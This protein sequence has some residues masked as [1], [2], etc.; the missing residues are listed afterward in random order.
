MKLIATITICI[1]M[2]LVGG[3][4]NKKKFIEAE[5]EA[6]VEKAEKTRNP[7][8]ILSYLAKTS[9]MPEI[10]KANAYCQ[11]GIL[12]AKNEN[13]NEAIKYY[14]K[15]LDTVDNKVFHMS[16]LIRGTVLSELARLYMKNKDYK[17]A[18]QAYIDLL[19]NHQQYPKLKLNRMGIYQEIA[20]ISMDMKDYQYQREILRKIL[21]IQK[22]NSKYKPAYIATTIALIAHSYNNSKDYQNGVKW[23]K[24]AIRYLNRGKA[25][26]Y[27]WGMIY[28]TSAV[29]LYGNMQKG[30]AIKE[31]KLACNYLKESKTPS[32]HAKL[33]SFQKLLAKWQKGDSN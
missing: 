19:K 20:F 5:F 4:S 3:C 17:L 25:D 10:S 26:K 22:N 14:K 8:L 15:S 23:A 21:A 29:S 7:D 32:A 30:K 13:D 12:F 27:A 1:I 9:E 18:R 24:E 33:K 2:F 28:Y 11:L 6:T 31:L 16:A